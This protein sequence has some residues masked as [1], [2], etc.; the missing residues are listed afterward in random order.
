[1]VF[2][3]VELIKI[4]GEYGRGEILK[5]IG[6]VC[7]VVFKYKSEKIFYVVGDMVWYVVVEEEINIY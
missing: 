6:L 5:C 7:G 1:M 2:E 4:K 3:G